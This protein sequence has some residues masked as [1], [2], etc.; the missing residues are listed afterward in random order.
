MGLAAWQHGDIFSS[1][2]WRDWRLSLAGLTFFYCGI[3]TKIFFVG[4][5][6]N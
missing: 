5:M 3:E 1:A 6:I 4:V 2:G